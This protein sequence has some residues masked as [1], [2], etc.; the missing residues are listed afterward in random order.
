VRHHY[1]TLRSNWFPILWLGVILGVTLAPL[2][3]TD[4]PP[5]MLCVLCGD[6]AL[7]DGVLN[8]AL[9]LPLGAALTVAGWRP[10]RIIALGA[11]LSCGVETAQ[12]VIPGRDP[13]LS[14]VLFNTLGEAL[15]VALA[16]SA[17]A[18]W[19]P[20]PRRA[21]VLS[22]AGTL[23]VASVLTLT[24]FCWLHRSPR[25]S[26]TENGP[27]VSVISS[28]MGAESCRPRSTTVRPPR[29]DALAAALESLAADPETRRRL[30]EGGERRRA[31][32][33][34]LRQ[35]RSPCRRSTC[36]S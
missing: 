5:R 12:L 23:G 4:G 9:F 34:S 19:R 27:R 26:T 8:A 16:H 36:R 20:T 18:V 7:A 31:R 24:V 30:G 22:L 17:P 14:D 21:D 11:L 13:S 3:A 1:T 6:G 32:D 10:R 29:P 2:E 35:N 33:F 28:G 25:T 15:G